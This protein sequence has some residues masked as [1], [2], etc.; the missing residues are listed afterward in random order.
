[1]RK[2]HCEDKT[3]WLNY[4][5]TFAE[6]IIKNASEIQNT[7]KVLITYIQC[8]PLSRQPLKDIRCTSTQDLSPNA[9]VHRLF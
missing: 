7:P 8:I 2:C 1:M 9:A 4:T 3:T 6:K 5:Y